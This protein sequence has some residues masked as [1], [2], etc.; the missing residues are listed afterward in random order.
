MDTNVQ[1]FAIGGN[2]R[3]SNMTS[4]GDC[5]VGRATDMTTL[6]SLIDLVEARRGYAVSLHGD[7]GDQTVSGEMLLAEARALVRERISDMIIDAQVV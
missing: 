3:L 1:V 7:V 4:T 2:W 5:L 6:N